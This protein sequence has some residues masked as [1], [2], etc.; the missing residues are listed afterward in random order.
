MLLRFVLDPCI[1][2]GH[3][4]N[5]TLLLKLL[6]LRRIHTLNDF[7]EQLNRKPCQCCENA[8]F[9]DEDLVHVACFEVGFEENDGHEVGDSSRKHD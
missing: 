1:Y 2:P 4:L 7:V 5:G 3:S 8:Y 9:H 6:I